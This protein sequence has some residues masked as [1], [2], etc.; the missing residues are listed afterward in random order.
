MFDLRQFLRDGLRLVRAQAEAA[1]VALHLPTPPAIALKGDER[2]L[3]K[4]VVNLLANAIKFTP[5]GEVTVSA[6]TD[7]AG[8]EI[9]IADTG[10]GI[11]ADQLERVL[12]P[13]HQVENELS[14]TANGT[15]LPLSRKLAERHGGTP[16]LGS[17]VG[18]GTTA[19]L[20]LPGRAVGLDRL[21]E[22]PAATA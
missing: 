2:R 9:R 18:R 13:F 3:R 1:G 17:A 16:V 15:G 11:P 22:A 7:S 19:I 5:R 12:E 6:V 4:C 20:S 8:I 14:R 21:W 10:C